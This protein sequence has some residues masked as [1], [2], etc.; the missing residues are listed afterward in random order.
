MSDKLKKS[1]ELKIGAVLSQK[2]DSSRKYKTGTWRTFRPEI[3]NSKCIN[4]MQCVHFCPE[5]CIALKNGKRGEINLDYCKGCGIC[6]ETC[7]V[8]AIKMIEE[9]E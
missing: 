2:D 4:C 3:D 9:E 8:K 1:Q 7:P 5:N 6:A